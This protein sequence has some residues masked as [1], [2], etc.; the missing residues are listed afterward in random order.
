MVRPQDQEDSVV[1]MGT[2]MTS[3]NEPESKT[4]NEVSETDT[5]K[6]NSERPHWL[7]WLKTI[8]A[9]VSL[10]FIVIMLVINLL[11]WV[12][13]SKRLSVASVQAADVS[14]QSFQ[15]VNPDRD[16]LTL[17]TQLQVRN[18]GTQSLLL[19]ES[20][21]EIYDET[22]GYLIGTYEFPAFALGAAST[23]VVNI[24]GELRIADSELMTSQLHHLYKGTDLRWRF[25][26]PKVP[27]L[28][29][30]ALAIGAST[31]SNID[32]VVTLQGGD[33]SVFYARN[34]ELTA[35]TGHYVN[36]TATVLIDETMPYATL[37]DKVETTFDLEVEGRNGP[38]SR[39]KIGTITFPEVAFGVQRAFFHDV[40]IQLMHLTA[41]NSG[42]GRRQGTSNVPDHNEYV[43]DLFGDL[44][45]AREVNM[46]MVGPVE[47]FRAPYFVGIVDSVLNM[48]LGSIDVEEILSGQTVR[49][50]QH[51]GSRKDQSLTNNNGLIVE[52]SSN[53]RDTDADAALPI[54]IKATTLESGKAV[55]LNGADDDEQIDTSTVDKNAILVPLNDPVW[56]KMTLAFRNQ[57][58]KPIHYQFTRVRV[59]SV[60]PTGFTYDANDSG[61]VFLGADAEECESQSDFGSLIVAQGS[62]GTLEPNAFGSVDFGL[63]PLE[64]DKCIRHRIDAACCALNYGGHEIQS[65]PLDVTLKFIM[66]YEAFAVPVSLRVTNLPMHCASNTVWFSNI[67]QKRVT[68]TCF[69]AHHGQT[70]DSQTKV[71]LGPYGIVSG[72][73][74]HEGSSDIEIIDRTGEIDEL[75][76]N[77][78]EFT[79]G[80]CEG[81]GSDQYGF[82][83]LY[84][85]D[86]C[87]EWA[88][89]VNST[90]LAGY[91]CHQNL[92]T[93]EVCGRC[94]IPERHFGVIPE[95]TRICPENIYRRYSIDPSPDADLTPG[96]K[97]TKRAAGL[98]GPESLINQGIDQQCTRTGFPSLLQMGFYAWQ[99]QYSGELPR[100]YMVPWRQTTGMQNLYA[101]PGSAYNLS[102][103]LFDGG[104]GRKSTGPMAFGVT[105]L[106]WSGIENRNAY[107]KT[108]QMNMLLQG[109]H[110]TVEYLMECSKN[111][112]GTAE[113][114]LL[115]ELVVMVGN[116][117]Y[118]NSVWERNENVMKY[119]LIANEEDEVMT[120]MPLRPAADV[121]A[122]VAAALTAAAMLYRN[123]NYNTD[124]AR[125]MDE[126]ALD[127]LQFAHEYPGNADQS[128]PA[129]ESTY[130]NAD[131][132]DEIAWALSW[133][134][135]ADTHKELRDDLRGM[136]LENTS[137]EDA[138]LNWDSKWLG[139]RALQALARGRDDPGSVQSVVNQI[140]HWI[141]MHPNL[142]TEP[143]LQDLIEVVPSEVTG[144]LNN[145][146]YTPGGMSYP[147][148][149]STLPSVAAAS[150]VANV[151]A[152]QIE[153]V[154]GLADDA[155]IAAGLRFW[156]RNQFDYI[157]G[158]NPESISLI[159]GYTE[160]YPLRLLHRG[161]SC[162]SDGAECDMSVADDPAADVNPIYGMMIEGI[163][164]DD[165]YSAA[166]RKDSTSHGQGAWMAL[167]ASTIETCVV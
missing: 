15:I 63:S 136:Y 138:Y 5:L 74:V 3:V 131:Y 7:G 158:Q 28:V 160:N 167:L 36:I 95:N 159:V 140:M 69:T 111:I 73:R 17:R 20:D 117:D 116:P 19:Q 145:V 133:F 54:L 112:K 26:A 90:D 100:D 49:D 81:Q 114:G 101:G 11:T 41:V 65:I 88:N 51:G 43:A 59:H 124:L 22:S 129:I 60:Y 32:K 105:M 135:F 164:A 6:K 89:S 56:T 86:E 58:N 163:N 154:G 134:E 45:A 53:L 156:A 87:V 44:L 76:F 52:D 68:G 13:I 121:A 75:A 123:E 16:H 153:T 18:P 141:Y 31:S 128:F 98:I 113:T 78:L 139:V 25:R 148:S 120:A 29:N 72:G 102:G 55:D 42:S 119:H 149:F 61:G 34:L 14:V 99:A 162:P 23:S 108:G 30:S 157:T 35:G 57:L 64:S 85:S 21:V 107:V 40:T 46:H 103:G 146:P 33:E 122:D 92:R 84:P 37:I 137:D 48:K 82:G 147:E 66:R 9:A 110:H 39:V 70:C 97:L 24:E 96:T 115:R 106:A 83:Y 10:L 12:N 161:S 165:T 132:M 2:T 71:Q 127:L 62:S 94:W 109:V 143:L 142:G 27:T 50:R 77:E 91:G 4:D 79:G 155:T 93:L 1:S 47:G 118:Y 150:F 104:D 130:K 151:L 125:E 80:I 38:E 126:R 8:A 152:T 67:C 144:Q 166:V